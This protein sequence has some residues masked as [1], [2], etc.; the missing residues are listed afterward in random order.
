M[1]MSSAEPTL[2]ELFDDDQAIDQALKDAANHYRDAVG[3]EAIGLEVAVDVPRAVGR[4]LRAAPEFSG[5]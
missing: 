3:V 5:A 1:T 4:E 2:A